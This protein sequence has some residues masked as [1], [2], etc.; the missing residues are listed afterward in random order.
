MPWWLSYQITKFFFNVYLRDACRGDDVFCSF[1]LYRQE[2]VILQLKKKP[3]KLEFL[4][5]LQ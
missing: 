2:F 5:K 4:M 3:I 1:V